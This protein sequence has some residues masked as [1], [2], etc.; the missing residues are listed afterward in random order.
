MIESISDPVAKVSAIAKVAKALPASERGRKQAVLERATGLLKDGAQRANDADR[1]RLVS[2]IAEQWL[3][4]GERDRARLM[5]EEGNASSNV[6]Q[7]GYLG[8]LARLEPDQAMAQLQ[9]QTAFSDPSR[10][11]AEVTAIAVQLATDH[12]ADAERFFNL[13]D[14][15]TDRFLSGTDNLRLCNRLAR[16][17]P[18]RARRVAASLGETGGR[19]G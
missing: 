8:Q 13:R 5:L 2:V 16:V 15:R 19:T 1:L 11:D 3:D 4:V 14:G 17:D 18:T 6:F 12:P 7:T 9:K 10:R